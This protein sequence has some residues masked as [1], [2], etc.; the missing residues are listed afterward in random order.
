[1]RCLL[2]RKR[3]GSRVFAVQ[4]P[5]SKYRYLRS[6]SRAFQVEILQ[7]SHSHTRVIIKD[8][9]QR[10]NRVTDLHKLTLYSPVESLPAPCTLPLTRIAGLRRTGQLTLGPPA[11]LGCFHQPHLHTRYSTHTAGT[12][13]VC[14]ATALLSPPLASLRL[15][16]PRLSSVCRMPSP[17]GLRAGTASAWTTMASSPS[18]IASSS[19]AL[20]VRFR[21]P[22]LP[23]ST[24]ASPPRLRP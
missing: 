1:M 20:S 17:L 21:L 8:N 15:T 10:R 7:S 18:S 5:T 12:A 23:C 4:V 13:C 11:R 24:T 2:R 14:E 19:T 22:R 16:P 9:R 3:R 6:R